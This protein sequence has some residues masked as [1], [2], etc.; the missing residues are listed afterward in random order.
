PA[1]QGSGAPTP[2]LLHS[3]PQ[4]AFGGPFQSGLGIYMQK[5]CQLLRAKKLPVPSNGQIQAKGGGNHKKND[6]QKCIIKYYL[7][8][9]LLSR[10][11]FC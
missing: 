4:P 6:F 10:E 8:F 5:F 9:P 1:F 11:K 2:P 3:V 7:K